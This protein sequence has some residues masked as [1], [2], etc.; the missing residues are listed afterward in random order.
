MAIFC[1]QFQLIILTK[2]V[3]NLALCRQA[4]KSLAVNLPTN[5]YNTSERPGYFLLLLG[6]SRTT[7]IALKKKVF[8]DNKFLVRQLS[9]FNSANRNTTITITFRYRDQNSNISVWISILRY[10]YQGQ[11][12]PCPP[13]SPLVRKNKKL[14][15]PLLKI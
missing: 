14:K 6:L 7:S 9:L 2:Q 13:P 5:C 4:N 3:T 11:K 8:L 1:C 12:Q 15:I 10:P